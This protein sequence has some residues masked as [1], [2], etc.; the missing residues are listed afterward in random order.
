MHWIQ[1]LGVV[2]VRANFHFS[3]V[4]QG[5]TFFSLVLDGN[6]TDC[7][8]HGSV[9][10]GSAKRGQRWVRVAHSATS[11]LLFLLTLAEHYKR[12]LLSLYFVCQLHWSVNTKLKYLR[13]RGSKDG[14]VYMLHMR[15]SGRDHALLF[16]SDGDGL[17]FEQSIWNV[18]CRIGPAGLVVCRGSSAN[19][20]PGT[21]LYV[22]CLI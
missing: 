3:L 16:E 1:T 19:R 12:D 4:C 22:S 14:A 10:G 7:R 8:R 13:Q 6:K 20:K 2:A 15:R 11:N 18:W 21:L 9:C 5:R 17:F